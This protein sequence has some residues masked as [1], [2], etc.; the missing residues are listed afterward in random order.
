MTGPPTK[1]GF[2]AR[3]VPRIRAPPLPPP[4]PRGPPFPH[5]SRHHMK[6][7][8]HFHYL[9]DTRG[10]GRL[11]LQLQLRQ[12][13]AGDLRERA[14]GGAGLPTAPASPNSRPPRRAPPRGSQAAPWACT[15]SLLRSSRL[16][17]G[18]AGG[19]PG[20]GGHFA[21]PR[22]VGGGRRGARPPHRGRARWAPRRA[23]RARGRRR[24]LPPP[25]GRPV[26]WRGATGAQ[27]AGPAATGGQGWGWCSL[28]GALGGFWA[29]ARAS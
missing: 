20:S 3:V 26:T 28:W 16:S 27:G 19:W 25:R 6:N 10:C 21:P 29:G 24:S 14:R 4:P 23:G 1:A 8:L 17:R 12:A 11:K 15:E 13:A 5:P 18:R 2:P 9:P 7:K 22:G